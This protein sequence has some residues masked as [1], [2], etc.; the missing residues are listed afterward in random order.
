MRRPPAAIVSLG[1]AVLLLAV[2]EG[3]LR[4]S[5]GYSLLTLPLT[6]T[7]PAQA[8][9]LDPALTRGYVRVLPVAEGVRREWYDVLPEP[10]LRPPLSPELAAVVQQIQPLDRPPSSDMFKRW[11]TR[12]IQQRVC[13][14]DSFF[15]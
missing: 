11:N 4:L 15:Q 5:D 12:L 8:A 9:D 1:A 2:T 14:D 10:L 7:R 3:V 13:A 6:R